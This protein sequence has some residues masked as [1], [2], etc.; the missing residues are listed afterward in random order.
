MRGYHVVTAG[1]SLFVVGCA[2]ETGQTNNPGAPVAKTKPAKTVTVR[3]T[4]YTHSEG[5][6]SNGIGSRLQ[7]SDFRSAA[8]DWSRFPVGT[9]FTILESGRNYMVDDYGSAVVGTNTIDLYVP[10]RSEMNRWGVRKVTISITE[11]GSYAKSLEI[12]RPRRGIPYV[13]K[14]VENLERQR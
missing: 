11:L 10:T 13:R 7:C 12:L 1:L 8:A 6:R 2:P 5:P 4:A 9:K 3:T 14:M